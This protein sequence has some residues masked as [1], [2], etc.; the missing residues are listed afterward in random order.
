MPE[1]AFVNQV[2]MLDFRG[3]SQVP[4]WGPRSSNG[5]RLFTF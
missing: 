1:V 3:A 5:R 4:H 2:P